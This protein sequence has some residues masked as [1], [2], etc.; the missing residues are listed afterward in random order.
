V[1]LLELFLCYIVLGLYT[2]HSLRDDYYALEQRIEVVRDC[3]CQSPHYSPETCAAMKEMAWK[4]GGVK[5][6]EKSRNMGSTTDDIK[7]AEI[8]EEPATYPWCVDSG[9]QF[10]PTADMMR[11]CDTAELA[12]AR[13]KVN[14]KRHK[15]VPVALDGGVK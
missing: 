3:D 7:A 2:D 12:I 11:Q 9:Q 1:I 14:H 6:A 5:E 13:W 15:P 8:E 4:D 10:P